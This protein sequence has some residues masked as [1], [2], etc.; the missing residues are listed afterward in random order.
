MEDHAVSIAQALD[1]RR[2]VEADSPMA[3]GIHG[4]SVKEVMR[5][6]WKSILKRSEYGSAGEKKSPERV[7]CGTYEGSVC[8]CSS[9]SSS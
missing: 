4:L 6:G 8:V 2:Q 1:V 5:S 3:N 7:L 9:A